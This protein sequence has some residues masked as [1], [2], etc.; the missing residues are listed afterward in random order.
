MR[1]DDAWMLESKWTLPRL[2]AA[3]HERRFT[4]AITLQF[5][6]GVPSVLEIPAAATQIRLDKGPK[7]L[8]T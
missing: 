6:Q 3:L 7:S 2:L 8:D 4:G 5:G 1:A